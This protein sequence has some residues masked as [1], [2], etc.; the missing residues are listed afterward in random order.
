MYT[1]RFYNF[2]SSFQ[3]CVCLA[4]IIEMEEQISELNGKLLELDKEK[5][6]N[7]MMD[8]SQRRLPILRD[9]IETFGDNLMLREIASL[10][11]KLVEVTEEHKVSMNSLVKI[12]EKT[13]DALDEKTNELANI[14]QKLQSVNVNNQNSGVP[15]KPGKNKTVNQNQIETDVK[16]EITEVKVELKEEP[17]KDL[18]MVHD[19]LSGMHQN[20]CA[21]HVIFDT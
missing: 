20:Q 2:Y 5:A 7:P 14:K 11:A 9:F 15:S 19:N 12:H 3:L 10:K 1:N 17:L 13:Q 21:F 8:L 4:N 16:I 6:K 18:H